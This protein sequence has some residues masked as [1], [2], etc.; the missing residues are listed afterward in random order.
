MSD[1][2]VMGP[3]SG[4]A[5]DA[6]R[7]IESHER[8]IRYACA[9]SL[10]KLAS[11]T[12]GRTALVQAK[13]AMKVRVVCERNPQGGKSILIQNLSSMI[14]TIELRMQFIIR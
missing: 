6:V 8:H 10:H 13:R 11:S 7:I 1:G 2:L 4:S 3:P 5:L 9:E 12:R 14:R